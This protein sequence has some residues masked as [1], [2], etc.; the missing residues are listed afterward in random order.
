MISNPKFDRLRISDESRNAPYRHSPIAPF[1]LAAWKQLEN[2][3]STLISDLRLRH[4]LVTK[5]R[6]GSYVRNHVGG[7]DEKALKHVGE[8]H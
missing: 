6:S 5:S 7:G 2:Y 3:R 8:W 4:G 1:H